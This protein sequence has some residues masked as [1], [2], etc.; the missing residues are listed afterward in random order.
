MNEIGD[1]LVHGIE[2]HPA[3]T[4]AIESLKSG[5]E[6]IAICGASGALAGCLSAMADVARAEKPTLV[7][8]PDP[9][10]ARELFRDASFMLET[11]GHGDQDVFLFEELNLLAQDFLTLSELEVI[12]CKY[13]V[14]EN[15]IVQKPILIVASRASLGMPLVAPTRYREHMIT[16]K[17]GDTIE[18]NQ[19]LRKLFEI[20]YRLVSRVHEVGQVAGRGGIIDVFLRAENARSESIFSATRSRAFANS[21]RKARGRL[22]KPKACA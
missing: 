20:G 2:K 10:H 4:G 7:V 22:V 11:L 15:L 14:L 5:D 8:A 1:I 16:V 21:I 9:Q 19:F 18:K 13:W 12:L 3:V 6:R 17:L